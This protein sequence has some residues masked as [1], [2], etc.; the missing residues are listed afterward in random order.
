[1]QW[2]TCMQLP[3]VGHATA[4]YRFVPHALRLASL[5]DGKDTIVHESRIQCDM[6]AGTL[7]ARS[8]GAEDEDEDEAQSRA[9]C[10]LMRHGVKPC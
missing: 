3:R 2:V 9:H 8:D 5:C 7:T 1:M 6:V 10:D 4:L